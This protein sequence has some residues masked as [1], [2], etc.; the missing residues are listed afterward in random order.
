MFKVDPIQMSEQQNCHFILHIILTQG[1]G[2][3]IDKIKSSNKQIVKAP[4]TY[5]EMIQQL[6]Y[7][8]GTCDIF[9]GKHSVATA[10]IIAL[11]SV[12]EKYKQPFKAKA[13]E[14]GNLARK[15]VFAVDKQMQVWFESISQA[16]VRSDVDDSTLNFLGLVDSVQNG[17]F[18]QS[19][20]PTFSKTIYSKKR[21]SNTKSNS[22]GIKKQK[23]NSKRSVTSSSQIQEFKMLPGETWVSN[24]VGKREGQVKWDEN[25]WMCTRWFIWGRC[26]SNFHNCASHVASV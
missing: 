11:I 22:N 23:D 7:F 18:V 6:K 19:L 12:V 16:K 20:P 15:F 17:N 25:T 1:K 2:Q 3:T 10:S 14:E 5:L 13:I 24:F 8:A 26:F 9:F 21:Q 4:S